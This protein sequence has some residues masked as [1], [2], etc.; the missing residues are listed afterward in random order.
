VTTPEL[1]LL[2]RTCF[3][4][5]FAVAVFGKVRSRDAF[6]D[7]RH[8]L[9]NTGLVGR[10]AEWP[11]G[12]AMVIVE[13]VLPALLL[14]PYTASAGLIVGSATLVLFSAA[15]G[16][17]LRTGHAATCHCFGGEGGLLSARHI[18]RN[19]VLVAGGIT[20]VVVG[21]ADAAWHMSASR[22]AFSLVAGVL[23]GFV[24]TR[25]DEWSFAIAG[26]AKPRT[27]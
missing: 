15:I 5:I 17:S 14:V 19:L 18:V 9:G 12:V 13:A 10:R 6:E 7:F 1:D 3:A 24:F 22:I 21:G 27:S 16:I 26:E 11:I 2:M 8:S 20:A 25:W 23:L 4:L